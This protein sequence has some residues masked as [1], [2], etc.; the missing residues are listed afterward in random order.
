HDHRSQVCLAFETHPVSPAS[1][2]DVVV[3]AA[4][5][6]FPLLA[7]DATVPTVAPAALRKSPESAHPHLHCL[8]S[9]SPFPRPSPG[10]SA[11]T[12][13]PLR[14][15]PTHLASSLSPTVFA[16]CLPRSTSDRRLLGPTA[17]T[18]FVLLHSS[19]STG[20]ASL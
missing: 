18:A 1:E 6:R 10:S 9:L 13:Y 17:F 3:P 12:P 4:A 15:G 2:S 16:G 14:S 11:G 20:R 5:D 7:L 19:P 8:G